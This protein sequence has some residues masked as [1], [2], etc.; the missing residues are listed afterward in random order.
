MNLSQ[1]KISIIRAKKET[2][3]IH[4]YVLE[5]SLPHVI[6]LLVFFEVPNEKK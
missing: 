6:T 1:K 3:F 2:Y 5:E 4:S